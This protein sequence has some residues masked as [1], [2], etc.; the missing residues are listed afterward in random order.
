MTNKTFCLGIDIGKYHHQATLINDE[1]QIVGQSIRFDNSLS[2]F[3]SLLRMIKEHLPKSALIKV[4]MEATGHYFWHLK[5]YLLKSGFKDLYVFNPIMTQRLAKTRIRKV[6]NDRIDSLLIA[7]LTSK[8]PANFDLSGQANSQDLKQLK[9]LTRFCEKLKSQ[10][11][12]YQQQL[13][14]LTE[15]ICPEFVGYF[16]SIFLA[17]PIKIIKEYFLNNLNSEQLILQIVKTSR[18]RIGPSKAKDII[19][20]L[21]NSLGQGFRSQATGWQL[22]MILDSFDLIIKQ[23]TEVKDRII[24]MSQEIEEIKYLDS[25]PGISP[26]IASVILAEIDDINRFN[27][28]EQLTAFA[29]L[30]PSVKE[31]GEYQRTQGN[32]I[33]KRGSK[34]L[35]KQLYYAAKTA[36]IFDPELKAYYQKKKGQGKHY[37]VIV[38]A[39]ARKILERCYVVLKQ[40]RPYELRSRGQQDAILDPKCLTVLSTTRA[41]LYHS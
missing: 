16:Q 36:I 6:K 2:G 33:S 26:Y 7:Q 24:Q 35:R 11:R 19:S 15:R 1:Q 12:F 22:K 4:G 10:K 32:H 18:Q 13:S 8:Q 21:D 39:V 17:T 38:I 9:E 25:C 40:K 20:A 14:V 41:W 30:D 29:G 37:N 23:I 3:A 27:R 31:S 34:Y 28:P 5:D